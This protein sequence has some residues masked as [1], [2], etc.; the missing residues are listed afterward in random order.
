[1]TEE[2]LDGLGVA[3]NEFLQPY[4]FCC[5]YTQT[6]GHLH[7]YCR[8]LLSDLKRKTA[9]PIALA[10]GC[11]VRTLQEFL[12]DHLWQH[13]QVCAQLQRDVGA[14]LAGLP[15]DG[16]GIVG[17]IDETSAL[18]SGDQTPGV[19]RQ[20][21]GCVGKIDNGIVTVHLGVCKGRYKT[22][23]DAELFLPKDWAKDR[24]RCQAAG[25]PEDMEYRPK[26]QIALEEVDRAQANKVPLDWLTF[27]EGYG[28]VPEFACG[29]DERQLRFVGEVPKSLSCLAVNGPGQRPEV[30]VKGQRADD[31]VRQSPAFLNQPW[32]KVKL[33]RQTV[34]PQVWEVKAA[35]V[36]QMQDKEWSTR[37]YWLLWA[38]NVATGEEKYFLS[39]APPDAKLQ[40]LMRVAFRRWNVEH[41]FRVG[42][43]ELG[44]THY[45]GRNYTGL[46]RHQMLCLLMLTFVAGHTERLRGEK[47]GGDAGASVQCV[48]PAEP[49]VAGEPA[50]DDAPPAPAGHHRL[51]PAAQPGRTRVSP[52]TP[53][54]Q[55]AAEAFAKIRQESTIF[56]SP[57]VAL[58]C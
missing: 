26:W 41:T 9:E 18:K 57:T 47:S 27:D 10:A 37:T 32:L 23:I 55:K 51:P 29:L 40:T 8:G 39:N 43:S 14:A 34:G 33:S 21:L 48:E 53:P 25:I 2:E 7:T 42:K 6:F 22:L 5:G 13:T 19:Q 49:G 38:K 20:Y 28:M 12:R 44:F 17:L 3:L 24:D 36:W 4:L 54:A 35:Q 50:G 45:E 30:Q 15:D 58:Y 46:M 16:L 1:V 52:G 56:K 31:V 11:A